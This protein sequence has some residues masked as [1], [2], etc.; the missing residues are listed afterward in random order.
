[1]FG[2]SVL[3]SSSLTEAI[4]HLLKFSS[5]NSGRVKSSRT[6]QRQQVP[7]GTVARGKCL[8][9]GYYGFKGD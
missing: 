8:C 1:M 9:H 6:H 2:A 7:N 5:T 4:L 3:F